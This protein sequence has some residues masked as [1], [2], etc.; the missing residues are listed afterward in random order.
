MKLHFLVCT[1][2]ALAASGFAKEVGKQTRSTVPG[3]YPS[4]IKMTPAAE[5]G[6]EA[7]KG[8]IQS[9]LGGREMQF[10]QTANH[11]GSEQLALAELART[12]SNS[13]QIKA[14]AETL[15]TAQV[16]ESKE[17]ARLAAAKHL[18]LDGGSA[19]VLTEEMA[20]LSGGKFEKAWVERLISINEA[21]V[22][23]YEI[24]AKSDD[25]DIRSFA[26][27]MLPVAQARL[28]L[29]N[30][31]G[32]RSVGNKPGSPADA[33]SVRTEKSATSPESKSNVPTKP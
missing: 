20:A 23:A 31:L 26:E 16:T 33:D 14:V 29:A 27:K 4:I 6:K 2:L 3:P 5:P 11:T 21:G 32:G 22:A 24:G 15:A 25:P 12:K 8:I 9:E 30:R 18:T 19:K 13:E 28:H 1:T 7:P 17:I 10:L